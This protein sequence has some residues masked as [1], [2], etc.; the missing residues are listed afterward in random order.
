MTSWMLNSP[1]SSKGGFLGPSSVQHGAKETR[2]DNAEARDRKERLQRGKKS[3]NP[4]K[5]GWTPVQRTAHGSMGWDSNNWGNRRQQWFIKVFIHH[6]WHGMYKHLYRKSTSQRRENVKES[7]RACR[8][9]NGRIASQ[10]A[11]LC[12]HN[13]TYNALENT[14]S[15]TVH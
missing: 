14:S 3:R 4:C 8:R 9:M 2:G 15:T 1:Q 12:L 13:S 11:D 10:Q 5:G 7:E 6:P